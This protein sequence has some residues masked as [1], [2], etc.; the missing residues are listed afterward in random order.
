MEGPAHDKGINY[1]A[2]EELFLAT[3]SKGGLDVEYTVTLS[4]VEIYNEKVRDL[5]LPPDEKKCDRGSDRSGSNSA[6]DKGLEVR[7]TGGEGDG[8]HVPGLTQVIVLNEQ[9]VRELMDTRVR[10]NRRVGTTNMN[11]HSSRSHC[12]VFVEVKGRHPQSEQVTRGRLVLIDLAGSERVKKSEVSG[13][14]LK[15]AQ[16][17]NKSLAALGDVLSALQSSQKHVPYRNS[18]LTF[19]L[20]DCLGGSCKCI[21]F[22][23]LSPAATSA[24]E[25]LCSLAFATRAQQTKLG[26]AK[27]QV[28]PDAQRQQERER[29]K[30]RE[31]RDTL[32]GLVRDNKELAREKEAL[33]LSLS[34][35]AIEKQSLAAQLHE[36]LKQKQ[37]AQLEAESLRAMLACA[38]AKAEKT[39]LSSSGP[40]AE[41]RL[42]I[43]HD[44]AWTGSHADPALNATS[45][46]TLCRPLARGQVA[47]SNS[48]APINDYN[49]GDPVD[50]ENANDGET[51]NNSTCY[52]NFSGKR[53]LSGAGDAKKPSKTSTTTVAHA[54]HARKRA[55]TSRGADTVGEETLVIASRGDG[56]RPSSAGAPG[57]DNPNKAGFSL[58]TSIG[59]ST[60]TNTIAKQR[61]L[62]R[63][64]GRVR[65]AT[66]KKGG[67]SY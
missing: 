14:A 6:N 21:M 47:S 10:P 66:A 42:T 43:I 15:E 27:K 37:N 49:R 11:A 58:P 8:V 4:V 50:K 33:T 64:V 30:E 16:H 51:L 5:L 9:H 44:N 46:Q 1:R 25:S 32:D 23:A 7:A 54:G 38:L 2:L 26:R 48:S 41:P 12:L 55:R 56:K 45:P 19:L 60:G 39:S 18:K 22:C 20:Q 62:V 24:Q 40:G 52:T 61:A 13:Q 31:K 65:Q 67:W 36:A 29:E 57:F 34:Q 28:L 17:I 3:A 53:K 59:F 63:T 35:R